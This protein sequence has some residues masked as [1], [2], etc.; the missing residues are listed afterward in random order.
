M[1]SQPEHSKPST[2]DIFPVKDIFEKIDDSTYV[3]DIRKVFY[4]GNEH[5]VQVT[6]PQE[7]EPEKC[8]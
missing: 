8:G 1:S 7:E 5:K 3:F 2:A 6:T 4:Y